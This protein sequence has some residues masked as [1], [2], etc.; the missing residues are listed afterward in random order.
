MFDFNIRN[1]SYIIFPFHFHKNR[2]VRL[3]ITNN[4]SRQSSVANHH[5]DLL[6]FFKIRRNLIKCHVVRCAT[7]ETQT[8]PI[9]LNIIVHLS[10]VVQN[11][12]H[13][14]Y[15]LFLFFMQTYS[16]QRSCKSYTPDDMH[17]H[18]M[19]LQENGC[20]LWVVLVILTSFCWILVDEQ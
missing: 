10:P 1:G 3:I 18:D 14:C 5:N 12:Y 13:R 19:S 9:H 6:S 7:D 17:K 11:I 16:V 4:V 8:R 15:C 20:S 2:R